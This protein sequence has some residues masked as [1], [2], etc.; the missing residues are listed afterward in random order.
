MKYNR[1][2]IMAGLVIVGLLAS[3]KKD[4]GTN[5][6]QSNLNL[7]GICFKAAIE[8]GNPNAKTYLDGQDV[9]WMQEDA[10]LVTNASGQQAAFEV[11]DGL[12]SMNGTFYTSATFDY[13]PDYNAAYPYDKASISGT[14]ATFTLPQQQP[15]TRTGTFG[16]GAMPMVAHSSTEILNFYNVCGGICFPL[17]GAGVHVS[18]LVLTS[19]DADDMLWGEFTADCTSA[20]PLPTHVDGGS[21]SN[22]I[23]LTCDIDLTDEAQDFYIMVPPATMKTGFTLEIYDGTT[24]LFNRSITWASQPDFITRSV[25]SKVETALSLGDPLTVSTV[26]PTFIGNTEAYGQG[27]VT[28]DDDNIME[29]GL[30]WAL[31]SETTTP[32]L[33]NNYKAD[34]SATAG[35]FAFMFGD[36]NP[37]TKD[38]VYYVRAYAKNA[39]GIPFYG[40]PIPFA[41]RKDYANDYNGSIP[42]AFSVAVNRQVNF[43]SGNL[44]YLGTGYTATNHF[45]NTTTTYSNN[46]WRFAEY[47]FE[48]VGGNAYGSS[49]GNVYANG[50]YP[51]A[52][53]N[54]TKSN[55]N[56][57]T[58]GASNTQWIDLFGWGTSG[59]HNP[60]DPYNVNYRPYDI[61]YDNGSTA[62]FD[63]NDGAHYNIPMEHNEY[64][65]GPSMGL[66]NVNWNLVG[67]SANYD[68]GVYN[69]I[70]NDG[71]FGTGAWRTMTCDSD[72]NHDGEWNYLFE[73]RRA[74][75][76]NGTANARFATAQLNVR[77]NQL[78]NGVMLF[79]DNYTWPA[80][81]SYYPGS[82]NDGYA[83]FGSDHQW[84]EAEWS[85]LE[86]NG[87]V[88]L[89]AAG[90]REDP[91]TLVAIPSWVCFYWSVTRGDAYYGSNM[92]VIYTNN[93]NHLTLG[94]GIYS[95]GHS[96][97]YQG[98][99]VRLVRNVN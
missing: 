85:L 38:C 74:S 7:D 22:S 52:S 53:Q 94:S 10:I 3:C 79:P 64:G 55:N 93:A 2:I 34:A 62:T 95:F 6:N 59:Y 37:L 50:E 54:G 61:R 92:Y 72:L 20:N 68:W 82:I 75:T 91:S 39:L 67:T 17:K 18:K 41:T 30:C 73:Q 77:L 1:L 97:H 58:N 57:I 89:P 36:T 35:D 8:Q 51:N 48:W 83:V 76:I 66:T 60:D 70:C 25:V 9:K 69:N 31:A 32:T 47:Q 43:S 56:N 98:Q 15:I 44:Q 78:V 21:G 49:Y 27:S 99:S 84:T 29:R 23:E 26:S 13:A 12:N 24:V 28:G 86:K 5:N 81:V 96:I 14:T 42:Y 19:N 46:T 63:W 16:N 11:V 71:S 90:Y 87:A 88:F 40:E 65:Y 45:L 80:E 4:N 33:A